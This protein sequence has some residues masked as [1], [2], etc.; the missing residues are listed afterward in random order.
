MK[1]NYSITQRVIMNRR[2]SRYSITRPTVFY[3]WSRERAFGQAGRQLLAS[4]EGCTRH[5]CVMYV[6]STD[7]FEDIRSTSSSTARPR[8][9]TSLNTGMAAALDCAAM[10]LPPGKSAAVAMRGEIPGS[11]RRRTGTTT[12]TRTRT[13]QQRQHGDAVGGTKDVDVMS[14]WWM[15]LWLHLH[16]RKE[17]PVAGTRG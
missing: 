15:E 11:W 1:C 5:P 7:C 10:A 2:P 16:D 14:R 8:S 13:G 12:R 3:R 9:P 6:S 17:K 4:L